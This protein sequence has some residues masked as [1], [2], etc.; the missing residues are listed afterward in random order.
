[1][2]SYIALAAL[3]LL[4]SLLRYAHKLPALK[5]RLPPNAF[6]SMQKCAALVVIATPIVVLSLGLNPAQMTTSYFNKFQDNEASNQEFNALTALTS[7]FFLSLISTAFLIF[8][9]HRTVKVTSSQFVVLRKEMLEELAAA[10][11]G[12]DATAITWEDIDKSRPYER[13]RRPES[14][15]SV[16]CER[17]P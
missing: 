3:S 14:S 15:A 5:A 1:L 7:G 17:R 16:E 10:T 11:P 9:L 8:I 6:A 4:S 2:R 12:A 13:E